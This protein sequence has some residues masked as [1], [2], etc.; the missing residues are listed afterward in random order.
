M[1]QSTNMIT[2]ALLLMGLI[3]CGCNGGPPVPKSYPVQGEVTLDDKPM[4]SGE[5]IFVSV[6]EG[7]RDTV[8]VAD[9]KFSGA[10]LAGDRKIEIRSYIAKEGNTKMYGPNA[11]PSYVNI[12]PKKYNEETE[13]TATVEESDGNSYSFKVTS[14]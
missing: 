13:L 9:G 2:M 10:V 5:V 6:A 11:E 14:S 4:P 12:I 3:S 1:N 7:I 8:K